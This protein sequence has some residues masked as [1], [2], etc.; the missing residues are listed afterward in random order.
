MKLHLF[1]IIK[2]YIKKKEKKGEEGC[3]Y[4]VQR[5]I[6]EEEAE[7]RRPKAGFVNLNIA[8]SYNS[9]RES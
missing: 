3:G 7:R 5:K 9:E 4:V 1:I 6:E 2:S 8:Y